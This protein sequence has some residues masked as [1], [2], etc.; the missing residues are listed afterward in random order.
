MTFEIPLED[1]IL[2]QIRL[3][4]ASNQWNNPKVAYMT[5]NIIDQFG[6]FVTDEM[7]NKTECPELGA[8]WFILEILD[9]MKERGLIK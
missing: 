4:D 6:P 8:P 9:S 7:L 2:H 3:Y 1:L 5:S